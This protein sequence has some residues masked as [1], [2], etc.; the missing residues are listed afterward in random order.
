R[1]RD[2]LTA[3]SHDEVA[4][5]IDELEIAVVPLA[6]VAGMHPAVCVDHLPGC[7]RLAPIA[8]EQ[9]GAAAEDLRTVGKLHLPAAHHAPD[10]AGLGECRVLSRNERA[11][12]LGLAVGLHE[13]D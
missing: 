4:R 7:L 1:R 12:G 5:P 13:V 2:G 8:L 9:I 11:G 3:G 6:A 10:I